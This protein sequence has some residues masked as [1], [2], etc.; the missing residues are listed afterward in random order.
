MFSRV[1]SAAVYG[2]DAYIVNVETDV[3]FGLPTFDMSGALGSKV[4]EA[5][6]RVRVAIKNSGIELTP[7]KIVINISPANIRKEGTIYDLP[8]A[9]GILAANGCFDLKIL[10]NVL[11]I[12]E[13][14]LDGSINPVKGVLPMVCAAKE[15]G[16]DNCKIPKANIAEGRIIN[17][18]NIYGVETLSQT[19]EI[20]KNIAVIDGS[21]KDI[22]RADV[23][24][25]ECNKS[26]GNIS[27]DTYTVLERSRVKFTYGSEVKNNNHS[28]SYNIDYSDISGQEAAKRATMIAVSGMHNIM[29]IGP[30]GSGKTM[31]AQRIP[32]IMPDMDYEEQLRLT[33]IYSVAGLLDSD[34]G[35]MVKR[36]FRNPHHTITQAALLGGGAVPRPGEITL[37]EGGVLFL[38]EMTEFNQVIM[39]ALRQ[40]LEDKV[41]TLVRV[42]AAYTYPAHFMLAAAINPCKCGYYPDRNRCHCSEYD[43]RRYIGR[44]SNPMWDRFDM[45]VKVDEVSYEVMRNKGNVDTIYNSTDMKNKVEAARQMQKDRFKKLD[46]NYNSQMG[47]REIHKYCTLNVECNELMERM[48]KQHHMSARAYNKV[49]KTARTIA[50]LKGSVNIEK[51]HLTEALFYKNCEV[52]S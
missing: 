41:I 44:I 26:D 9:I 37:S 40:P 17:N 24:S 15:A 39:E 21:R 1:I 46:I 51:E 42:N 13:V 27:N 4:R 5:K 35:I 48:Y 18:I 52:K 25:C 29:Y 19:I 47:V 43:I 50:D 22:K 33:K 7:Q 45:C 38:D 34:G 8:I 11:I 28:C 31:L 12:G 36:P 2:I 30:P 3:G 6:D 23:K 20:L 16:I 32:T 49:L 10:E 14:S